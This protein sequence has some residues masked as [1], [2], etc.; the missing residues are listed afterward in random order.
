MAYTYAN[1]DTLKLYIDYRKLVQL[2]ND[3]DLTDNVDGASINETILMEMENNAAATVDNYLRN[4]FAVP[5]AGIY[6]TPEIK[7]I[8]SHLTLSE[9]YYRRGGPVPEEYIIREERCRNRLKTMASADAVENR[10]GRLPGSQMAAAATL[11]ST[12]R[13]SFKNSGL[14]DVMSAMGDIEEDTL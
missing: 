10:A 9:L 3:D 6:L 12:K 5:L 11:N 13:G 14:L 2:T 7:R 4:A 8:V 1:L